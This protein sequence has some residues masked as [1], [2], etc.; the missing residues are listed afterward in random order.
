MYTCVVDSFG[1][2]GVD[3]LSVELS[4]ILFSKGEGPAPLELSIFVSPSSLWVCINYGHHSRREGAPPGGFGMH[5][6]SVPSI[7]CVPFLRYISNLW[8]FGEITTFKLSWAAIFLCVFH[9][10]HRALIRCMNHGYFLPILLIAYF[11]LIFLFFEVYFWI[12][13]FL[14]LCLKRYMISH[15]ALIFIPLF[16][17]KGFRVLALT[18]RS[19]IHLDLISIT[20]EGWA[21]S[22]VYGKPVSQL[23]CIYLSIDRASHLLGWPWTHCVSGDG[24][25][26]LTLLSLPP[27]S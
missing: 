4:T 22:F 26:L 10:P 3:L 14:L 11:K 23:I 18:F 15:K 17:S 9:T 16:S 7:I 24:L 21:Y 2:G 25:E 13:F 5:L 6:P 20:G 8:V 12:F 19:M 1:I 27:E